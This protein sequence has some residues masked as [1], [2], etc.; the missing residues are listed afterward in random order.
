MAR[1]RAF[2]LRRSINVWSI[3]HSTQPRTASLPSAARFRGVRW[4][5][6]KLVAEVELRGWTSDGL[7]RHASYKGIREDKDPIEVER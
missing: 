3:R 7:L 6:P 2:R 5:E 1:C 4:V